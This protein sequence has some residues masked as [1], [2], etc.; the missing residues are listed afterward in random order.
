MK[1][2]YYIL[3]ALTLTL[4][5]AACPEKST[6]SSGKDK[7]T[8]VPVKDPVKPFTK[9]DNKNPSYET[10]HCKDI[11]NQE[12][13]FYG[14]MKN[15]TSSSAFSDLLESQG[16][17][18][19]YNGW[20]KSVNGNQ[21]FYS[22]QAYY[23]T[24]NCTWWSQHGMQIWVAF[25][26]GYSKSASIAI[27]AT[28]DGWTWGNSQGFPVRRMYFNAAIDCNQENLTLWTQT[29]RGWLQIVVP[30]EYGNKEAPSM[31]ASVYFNGNLL[32]KQLL[33]RKY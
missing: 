30:K 28:G 17:C 9:P 33:V 12:N 10:Q 16:G 5:L 27:D 21:V 20:M 2:L 4:G 15:I 18:S 29:N 25:H 1:R 23:G 19:T 24:S 26:K 32:G 8:T 14:Y 6:Y 13:L 3:I 31:R 11:Q 7:V 22:Y